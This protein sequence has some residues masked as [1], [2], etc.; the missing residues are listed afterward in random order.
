[1]MFSEQNEY[2]EVYFQNG[3][4]PENGELLPRGRGSRLDPERGCDVL[5]DRSGRR[6]NQAHAHRFH[7]YRLPQDSS[8]K[9][10]NGPQRAHNPPNEIFANKD[11]ESRKSVL[12]PRSLGSNPTATHPVYNQSYKCID[13]PVLEVGKV[14]SA[15]IVLDGE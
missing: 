5:F 6:F 7:A 13:I 4:C 3:G 10:G 14:K 2:H 8:G 12:N 9:F 1:M 15:A 11:S